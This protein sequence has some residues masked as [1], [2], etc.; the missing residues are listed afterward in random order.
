MMG[1]AE[2]VKFIGR[3]GDLTVGELTIRVKVTDARVQ[4]GDVHLKVEP[5]SGSGEQW[6]KDYRVSLDKAA[7]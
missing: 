5:I 3:E 1:A 6:V 4:W 2:L 7:A